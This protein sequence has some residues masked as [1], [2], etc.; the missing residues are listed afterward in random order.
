[1]TDARQ[2]A[3]SFDGDDMVLPFTVE[4]LD[5]RGRVVRL[6]PA[7]DA[8]LA[9]HGYPP[10][11][12]RVLGEAMAL[13]V[14]LG[15]SLKLEGRFQLQTRSDGPV[16]MLVVDFDAPD[17]LRGC[18]R[19]DGEALAAALAAGE[20]STGALLGAGHMALT[21]DQGGHASRYQGLTPLEG[22]SLE[23]CAHAYFRQS[24]QIPTFI[25]L[26]FGE[27]MVGGPQGGG[28]Y[29]AGGLMLQYLPRSPERLRQAD[30]DPAGASGADAP[31]DESDAW[32]EARLLAETTEAHELLDPGLPASRL[33]YRLYHER[34]VRV[35]TPQP[36][37]E[38]CR[39]S[40]ERIIN[41]LGSFSPAERRDMAADDGRIGVTCE[42]CSRRYELELAQVEAE[43]A[44]AA[45]AASGE[46][47]E[48]SP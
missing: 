15:S 37:R 24:E 45:M 8:V 2:D 41:M 23:A 30:L 29:R 14:L 43:L 40:R 28:R 31:G 36:V 6:G 16:N 18:A 47:G 21:I 9:R 11:V 20:T 44:A 1:M 12:S 38:A 3:P 10:A 5:V 22:K 4:G 25:R 39:C 26:A 35:F 27:E 34:G 33:L 19:F 17:R 7:V 13:T 42:F 48:R 46:G 32:T